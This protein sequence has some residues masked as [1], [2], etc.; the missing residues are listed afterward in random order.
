[1]ELAGILEHCLWVVVIFLPAYSKAAPA[2]NPLAT[3]VDFNIQFLAG[4]CQVT[5]YWD[6]T[7]YSKPY[8]QTPQLFSGV[9]VGPDPAGGSLTAG[10]S[11]TKGA[12][13]SFSGSVTFPT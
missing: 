6:I 10:E 9:E 12:S 8:F 13:W 4:Y 7:S 11:Y 5:T 1:M 3:D 2:S